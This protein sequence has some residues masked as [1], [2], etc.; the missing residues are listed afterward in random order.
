MLKTVIFLIA[1]SCCGY[2]V[3]SQST[4]FYTFNDSL[5]S[6]RGRIYTTGSVSAGIGLIGTSNATLSYREC[7]GF[8]WSHGLFWSEYFAWM[9]IPKKITYNGFTIYLDIQSKERWSLDSEDNDNF[10]LTQG[11]SWDQVNT[12]GN[13]CRPIGEKASLSWLFGGVTLNVYLPGDIPLGNY[14]IPIK[15]L[16]GIQRNNFDYIGGRHKIPSYIMKNFPFQSTYNFH[17]DNIGGC[18][19]SVQSLDIEHGSLSINDANGHVVTKSLSVYCDIPA[20]INVS[21]L[22]N[23]PGNYSYAGT[24]VGLGNGWDSIVSLD[25]VER[26]RETLRWNSAGS[27]T[28]T[29][30][31]RLY[32]ESGKIKPGNLSGS[33]TM[34]LSIR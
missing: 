14:T 27:K 26:N 7:N 25:G 9:V 33:M 19:P 21:L 34:V 22:P 11:Y 18:R 12:S 10:Y 17:I 15:F 6:A 3:A 30:G 4:V 8:T 24:S 32:G 29:V 28:I 31:S 13:T 23:T 16:R 20:S 1:I 2:A 5:N